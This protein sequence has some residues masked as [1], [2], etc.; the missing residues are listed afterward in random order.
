MSKLTLE[1][2]KLQQIRMQLFGKDRPVTNSKTVRSGNSIAVKS[3]PSAP[4]SSV[5]HAHASEAVFL[6]RDLVKVVLLSFL[7]IGSQLVLYYLSS[8]GI[9]NLNVFHLF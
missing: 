7:M 6:N 1:E 8:Q 5:S 2:K 3:T 9:I 4:M